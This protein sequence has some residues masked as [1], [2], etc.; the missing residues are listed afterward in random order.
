MPPL[1]YLTDEKRAPNPLPVISKLKPGTGVILRHYNSKSRLELGFEI[2]E[3]C[4]K[5]QLTFIVARDFSLGGK[6]GA[7]NEAAGAGER[8]TQYFRQWCRH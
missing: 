2:R 4:K 5:N 7:L 6:L 3:I 1:L 8:R